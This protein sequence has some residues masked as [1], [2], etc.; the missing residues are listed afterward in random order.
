MRKEFMKH[1]ANDRSSAS[2][3]ECCIGSFIVL[4]YFIL[5]CGFGADGLVCYGRIADI[6]ESLSGSK[7]VEKKWDEEYT[8]LLFVFAVRAC[9]RRI[10]CASRGLNVD[11]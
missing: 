9:G 11:I 5:E 3:L 8:L 10:S 2:M 1:R 6:L 7:M 4:V